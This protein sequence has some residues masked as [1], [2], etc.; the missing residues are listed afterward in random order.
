[1]PNTAK[2][3]EAAII[4]ARHLNVFQSPITHN[5]SSTCAGYAEVQAY[6]ALIAHR[7]KCNGKLND[8]INALSAWKTDCRKALAEALAVGA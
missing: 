2:R 6:N 3:I 7:P 4:E 8:K 1:M 5:L